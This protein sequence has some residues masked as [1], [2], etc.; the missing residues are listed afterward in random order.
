M[1]KV[2]DYIMAPFKIGRMLEWMY[3]LNWLWY[4]FSLTFLRGYVTSVLFDQ[5][6]QTIPYALLC[7]SFLV[8]ALISFLGLWKNIL[9]LRSAA[10]LINIAILIIVI[11]ASG[12][13]TRLPINGSLGFPMILTVLTVVSFWRVKY[14]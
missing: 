6:L 4:F 2:V 10:L 1:N 9:I 3:A 14:T 7:F 11:V 8:I 5:L 12:F 13:R